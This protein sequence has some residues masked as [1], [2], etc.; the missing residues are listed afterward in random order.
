MGNCVVSEHWSK[1]NRSACLVKLVGILLLVFVLIFIGLKLYVDWLVR[2]AE[3]KYPPAEFVTA[4]GV[5]LHYVS[6]G[7]GHPVVFF[8]GRNSKIQDFTLSP[9]FDTITTHYQGI[10]IDRPGLGYSERITGEDATPTVQVRFLHAALQQ[11]GIE[12]PLLVGQS[13]GGV[14]A[15][16]YALAYPDSLSGVVLLGSA[17]YP[18]SVSPDPLFDNI[19]SM[20]R[21]PILGDV[22]LVLYT[23]VARQLAPGFLEG[24]IEYFA[25]LESIPASYL[26]TT[27]V[28]T[29]RPDLIKADAE[30]QRFVSLGLEYV[31]ARLGDIAVPVVIVAGSL[32]VNAIDQAPRLDQDIPNSEMIV[33]DGAHH[34]FWYAHPEVVND[35]INRAWTLAGEQDASR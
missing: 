30:E 27:I 2:Q 11:L 22:F 34:Y 19:E 33:V 9:L 18:R 8:G 23:P 10:F 32:D 4:D 31:S 20:A 21:T 13:W 12:K 14:I 26:D 16:A 29:L 25:P 17:P 7:A 28:L 35:A 3:V 15:L 1:S 6:Q 5:R 24:E